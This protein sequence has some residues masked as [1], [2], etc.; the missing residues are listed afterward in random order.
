MKSR[1][2]LALLVLLVPSLLCADPQ[3]IEIKVRMD[4][5]S[6][7]PKDPTINLRTSDPVVLVQVLG[8]DPK[9]YKKLASYP[10]MT[11]YARD[12]QDSGTLR[13]TLEPTDRS[14]VGLSFRECSSESFAREGL[15]EIDLGLGRGAVDLLRAERREL[16]AHCPFAVIDPTRAGWMI[17]GRART[18]LFAVDAWDH[19]EREESDALVT[20]VVPIFVREQPWDL[21]WSAGFSLFNRRDD[22]YR[23]EAAPGEEESLT[24]VQVSDGSRPYQLSAFAHYHP[25]RRDWLAVSAGLATDVPVEDLSIMLGVSFALRTLPLVNSLYL[26]VGVSYSRADRLQAKFEGVETVGGDI[27]L[28]ELVGKEYGFGGFAA[29]TFG[30]AGGEEKFKGVVSGSKAEK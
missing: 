1:S 13:R 11:M 14:V 8:L 7:S 30:F 5:K 3:N 2:S 29:L 26:T 22:R 17:F 12:E 25:L 9:K 19:G 15:R 20:M 24:P 18:I 10:D 28:E 16:S 6:V 4:E 23:L 27:G 21:R